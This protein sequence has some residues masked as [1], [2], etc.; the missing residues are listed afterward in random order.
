MPKKRPSPERPETH[1][2]ATPSPTQPSIPA[3]AALSFLK[4]TK[5]A[6]TWSVRDLADALKIGRREAEQV[7]ALLAAQGYVQPARG[8]DEWLTTPAGESVSG[9]KP[10]R[11]TRESVERAVE[12]LKE[13]IKQVNKDSKS[14]F[15]IA[16]AVAFGDFLLSDRTRVQAPDVGIGLTPRGQ[17]VGEPRSAPAAKAERQFLRQ[18]RGKTALLY[19]RPYAA[20]MRKELNS[21]LLLRYLSGWRVKGPQSL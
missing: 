9:A 7:A 20:W 12:S 4:D 5:G 19:I 10:P 1:I 11:F 3:E 14:A 16:D 17:A 21:D 2:L 13:R 8:T 18:L 15:R 6:V